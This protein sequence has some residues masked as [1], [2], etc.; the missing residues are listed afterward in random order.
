[1]TF[2]GY[3]NR[4]GSLN[5]TTGAA[6]VSD[7]VNQYE[8]GVKNG[9]N[10]FGGRYTA[11]LTVYRSNFNITT[12][13]LSATKCG[14]AA[15]G[16][17]IANKYRTMGAEFYGTYRRGPFN[18]IANLTYNKAEKDARGHLCLCPFGLHS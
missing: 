12:Y 18:L 4:D 5:S 10:L 9:G 11:E 16:C 6:A 15:A 3:F 14:G 13:E 7:Y 8:V 2:N 1:M 17:I